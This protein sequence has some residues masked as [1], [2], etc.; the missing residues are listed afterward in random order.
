MRP[1][2]RV[3]PKLATQ[4]RDDT[5]NCVEISALSRHLMQ[6]KQQVESPSRCRRAF[7]HLRRRRS[8]SAVLFIGGCREG[9]VRPDKPVVNVVDQHPRA[10][11]PDCF[12]RHDCERHE[13]DAEGRFGFI[14]SPGSS[15]LFLLKDVRAMRRHALPRAFLGGR[16]FAAGLFFACTPNHGVSHIRQHEAS[17]CGPTAVA[18]NSAEGANGRA[19]DGIAS[20][21]AAASCRRAGTAAS[22]CRTSSS[23]TS[24]GSKAVPVSRRSTLSSAEMATAEQRR[25]RSERFGGGVLERFPAAQ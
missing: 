18:A 7:P 15:H 23:A 9:A 14:F 3:I 22:R 11:A 13:G 12:T 24:W 20:T 8:E 16:R 25:C 1:R 17:S 19:L 5:R 10:V 2:F 6:S 21:T 4:P